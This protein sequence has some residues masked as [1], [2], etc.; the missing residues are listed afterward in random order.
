MVYGTEKGEGDSRSKNLVA[1]DEN[2]NEKD[3]GGDKKANKKEKGNLLIT[4][5]EI[6]SLEAYKEMGVSYKYL[7]DRGD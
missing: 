7:Q 5:T 6:E 2:G 1:N 4:G 3:G